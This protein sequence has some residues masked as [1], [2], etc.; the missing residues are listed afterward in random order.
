M[1]KVRVPRE[2]NLMKAV[3]TTRDERQTDALFNDFFGLTEAEKHFLSG[4]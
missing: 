3:Q 1:E 2:Q 4:D